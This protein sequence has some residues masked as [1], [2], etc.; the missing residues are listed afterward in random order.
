MARVELSTG[1]SLNI[2]PPGPDVR[3]LF[4]TFRSWVNA[5]YGL[6]DPDDPERTQDVSLPHHL[7]KLR[8]AS[9]RKG[10]A[11]K[12]D[13]REAVT[14]FVRREVDAGR[15]KNRAGVVEF[16]KAQGFEIPRAGDN[17][18]TIKEPG[19]DVKIRL[20][21]GL[22]NKTN[23]DPRQQAGKIRYGIRDPERAAQLREKL[24]R[25]AASRAKYNRQRYRAKGQEPARDLT[26]AEGEGLEEYLTRQLGDEA[27]LAGDDG[28]PP[29]RSAQ[30]QQ[31]RK[32]L[33]TVEEIE[34][35]FYEGQGRTA[36]QERDISTMNPGWIP[37]GGR[38]ITARRL[39]PRVVECRLHLCRRKKTAHPMQ[40]NPT[41]LLGILAWPNRATWNATA[42]RSSACTA[43]AT[44]R[45][46]YA[47][48]WRRPTP[49][50][51]PRRRSPTS[52]LSCGAKAQSARPRSPAS[53]P[54]K[55]SSSRN[56]KC[57]KRLEQSSAQVLDAVAQI[58]ARLTTL[59]E[60]AQQREEAMLAAL[61]GN[62]QPRP[63]TLPAGDRYAGAG[64][65]ISW[66][67]LFVL[68]GVILSIFLAIYYAFGG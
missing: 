32:R 49:S 45:H 38:N 28:G 10:E 52:W 33:Q 23:F 40:N 2:A 26:P 15:V 41:L 66:P 55:S 68:I 63:G 21:G 20:K 46:A 54:R 7:A 60:A 59:E 56:T 62:P 5:E 24:E 3:D 44:R 11:Y 27:I 31:R 58:L 47:A 50:M 13:I 43:N 1:K 53:P 65:P 4:D 8:A 14:A 67:R 61:R 34:R 12:E 35:E 30:R 19:S 22:Y 29:A 51:C 64:N 16:L 42:T 25:L 6:A 9:T 18:V 17:Y 36:S 39:S 57:S 48:T 37:I